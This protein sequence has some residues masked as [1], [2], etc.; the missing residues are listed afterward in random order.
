MRPKCLLFFGIVLMP[1]FATAQGISV[2]TT[3]T[4]AD[5]SAIF[6]A[7]STTQGVLIPRMNST[8]MG[9]ITSPAT[10]LLIYCTDCSPIGFEFYTGT[11]WTSLNSYTNVTTQGNT[12]NGANQLVQTNASGLIAPSNLGTGLTGSYWDPD[13]TK[14]LRGNN[15]WGQ[16]VALGNIRTVSGYFN[17]LPTDQ[18]VYAN[19]A[20]DYGTYEYY[21]PVITLCH[22]RLV[23]RGYQIYLVYIGSGSYGCITVKSPSGTNQYYGTWYTTEGSFCYSA[24]LVSDGSNT[25]YWVR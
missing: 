24:T 23:P 25:W 12:F 4:T 22:P 2:N 7:Q 17:L 21:P 11:A 8:Q 15:T 3:G 5:A 10:G 6:D 9:M 18:L 16:P 1:F 13:S 20:P 19:D 14:F